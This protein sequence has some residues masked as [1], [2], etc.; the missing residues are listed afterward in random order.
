[1]CIYLSWGEGE[2]AV[3]GCSGVMCQNRKN[4]PNESRLPVPILLWLWSSSH[5]RW[6]STSPPLEAE[7]DLRHVSASR[8]RG[9][10]LPGASELKLWGGWQYPHFPSWSP[11]AMLKGCPGPAGKKGHIE[12]MRVG[13]SH[14]ETG[15]KGENHDA[16]AHSGNKAPYV[17]KRLSWTFQ[18]K[19]TYS[20]M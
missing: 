14:G 5:K 18:P 17:R 2:D 7:L 10:R 3:W 9:T 19:L 4:G 11:T 13:T 16:P 6:E 20:L 12:A 8:M 1:M 15:H